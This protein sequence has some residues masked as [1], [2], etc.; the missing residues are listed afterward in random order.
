MGTIEDYSS[1]KIL[2]DIKTVWHIFD[3]PEGSLSD[4]PQAIRIQKKIRAFKPKILSFPEASTC[5]QN[6][7]KVALGERV[8]RTLNPGSVSTES[9]FLDEL[10]DAMIQSGQA[11]PATAEEAEIAL[12][13]HSRHPLIISMV[14]GRYQEI[15]ASYSPDCVYW[16][17]EKRG[18]HCLKH[19][20]T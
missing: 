5:I 18:L 3:G 13:K 11:R 8:C 20:K 14:S 6:A 7:A 10:A 9:V 12:K 1:G 17:A 2:D 19:K 16:K 15:C 4:N